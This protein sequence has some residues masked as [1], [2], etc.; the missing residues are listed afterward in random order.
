[1][2]Y[3]TFGEAVLS[4]LL[5]KGYDIP[6]IVTPNPSNPEKIETLKK[7]TK[8]RIPIYQIGDY[9]KSEIIDKINKANPNMILACSFKS[10][11]P[12]EL[13][14]TFYGKLINIHGALLPLFRGANMLNWV[15]LS[16][17]EKTGVTLHYMDDTLDSGPILAEIQFPIYPTDDVISL[18]ARMFEKTMELLDDKLGDIIN[19]RITPQEQDHSLARYYPARK[20]DDGRIEWGKNA[21]DVHNLTR[22]LVKPY[23][24]AFCYYK[25]EKITLDKT[26]VE[27]TNKLYKRPGMIMEIIGGKVKVATGYN[28]LVINK[29]GE[30]KQLD[31]RVG[32]SFE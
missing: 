9:D 29:F 4:H 11:V 30:D 26:E 3:N 12:K 22:A 14:T 17:C 7:L 5:K 2:G 28:M 18:K 25:G 8:N 13:I 21:I 16:G 6:L 10:I 20:P 32:E 23:P 1:M 31:L 19:G 24:G 15:I 27:L